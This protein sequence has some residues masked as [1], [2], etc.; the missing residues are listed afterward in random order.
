VI[1]SQTM[2][3]ASAPIVP[4]ER[5][6][7]KSQIP[8]HFHLI[9]RHCPLRVREMVSASRRLTAVSVAAQ[10]RHHHKI[11]LRQCR[12]DLAPEH[13]RLRNTVQQKQRRTAAVAAVNSVDRRT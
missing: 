7:L 3:R 4:Y 10:I 6:F 2:R 8:H 12:R 5:E 11:V 1:E 9:L 13:M